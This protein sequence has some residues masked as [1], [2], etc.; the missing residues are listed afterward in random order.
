LG[1]GLLC[2][3]KNIVYRI[4]LVSFWAFLALD[5]WNFL[6]TWDQLFIKKE[7]KSQ[8]GIPKPPSM[9]NSIYGTTT[10]LIHSDHSAQGAQSLQKIAP[11]LTYGGAI[12]ELRDTRHHHLIAP[13]A[14]HQLPFRIISPE[15]CCRPQEDRKQCAIRTIQELNQSGATLFLPTT[16]NGRIKKNRDSWITLLKN[17]AKAYPSYRKHDLWWNILEAKYKQREMPCSP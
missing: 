15:H 11:S 14:Q 7:G 12:V 17:E 2:S 8:S 4:L 5:S 6:H 13:L 9:F 3:K 16:H 1:T 10:D